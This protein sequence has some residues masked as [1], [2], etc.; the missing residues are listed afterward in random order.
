ASGVLARMLYPTGATVP[1]TEV[2]ALIGAPGEAIPDVSQRSAAPARGESEAAPASV[3]S[4]A[5]SAPATPVRAMPAAPRLAAERGIDVKRLVGS[6]PQGAITRED[7]EHALQ[8][9]QA[10]PVPPVQKLSF[11]SDGVR[12][13]GILYTPDNLTP[14][15]RRGGVVLL[16]GFTYLKTL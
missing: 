16:A 10:R 9:S 4:L 2:I 12:L 3:T 15:E 8:L 7:V 1:V 5:A 6:G 14:G 11:F 13:D